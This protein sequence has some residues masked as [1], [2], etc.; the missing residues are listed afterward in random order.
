MNDGCVGTFFSVAQFLS[1][2]F[3]TSYK[4]GSTFQN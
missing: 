1:S 2:E 3:K 4:F